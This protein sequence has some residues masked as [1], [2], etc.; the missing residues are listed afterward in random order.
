MRSVSGHRKWHMALLR[1]WAQTRVCSSWLYQVVLT[2]PGHL[3]PDC[4]FFPSTQCS[5]VNKGKQRIVPSRPFIVTQGQDHVQAATSLVETVTVFCWLGNQEVSK[6]VEVNHLRFIK[7][8]KNQH[9]CIRDMPSAQL[10]IWWNKPSA[11]T[12]QWE[13]FLENLIFQ[14]NDLVSK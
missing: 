13:S 12:W 2:A 6:R 7:P 8:M 1:S 5:S 14:G 9:E 4:I 10:V 3:R 11:W